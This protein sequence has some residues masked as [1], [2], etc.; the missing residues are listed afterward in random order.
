ML[1]LLFTVRQLT[2][3]KKRVSRECNVRKSRRFPETFIEKSLTGKFAINKQ[4]VRE[5]NYEERPTRI[6]NSRERNTEKR[7]EGNTVDREASKKLVPVSFRVRNIK[8]SRR[9]C[10]E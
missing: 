5:E 4:S 2:V 10:L 6:E 9:N 7:R 8:S 1:I 3:Q